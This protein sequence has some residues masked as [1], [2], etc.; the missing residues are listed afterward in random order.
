M[1]ISSVA[2]L[3]EEVI[4]TSLGG[5]GAARDADGGEDDAKSEEE[6]KNVFVFEFTLDTSYIY[7]DWILAKFENVSV[8]CKA[9]FFLVQL[10]FFMLLLQSFFKVHNVGISGGIELMMI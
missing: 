1:F 6:D 9:F 3:H 10:F 5:I 2:E 7:F 8:K 4:C